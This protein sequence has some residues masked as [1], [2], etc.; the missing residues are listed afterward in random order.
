[1]NQ[2]RT[3]ISIWNRACGPGLAG[4]FGIR[5]GLQCDEAINAPV[6]EEL[7]YIWTVQ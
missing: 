2:L 5:T 3:A 7:N 4:N 6:L 1:M